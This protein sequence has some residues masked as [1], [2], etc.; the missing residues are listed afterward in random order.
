LPASCGTVLGYFRV[1]D[2][3]DV[4]HQIIDP[5]E[6]HVLVQKDALRAVNLV[7]CE[8]GIFFNTFMDCDDVFQ[9]RELEVV[10]KCW[11]ESYTGGLREA[12]LLL[13]VA[14]VRVLRNVCD[15]LRSC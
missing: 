13:D 1:T 14:A 15:S 2:I 3:V 6:V 12:V 8:K 10:E 5:R 11:A 7:E 4:R 9:V